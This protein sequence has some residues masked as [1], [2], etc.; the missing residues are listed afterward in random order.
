MHSQ[1][2]MSYMRVGNGHVA[3]EVL[4]RPAI[5]YDSTNGPNAPDMEIMVSSY[6]WKDPSLGPFEI[7]GEA[8]SITP[9]SIRP[10]S[11]GEVRLRSADPW[12]QPVIDPKY[13][14]AD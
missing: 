3:S 8:M 5:E 2:C 13:V 14:L 12:D 10:T 11:L 7:V 9:V 4:N 1:D 6:A